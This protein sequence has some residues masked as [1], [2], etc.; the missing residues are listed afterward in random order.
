[1]QKKQGGYL[2]THVHMLCS[3]CSF[4]PQPAECIGDIT[5]NELLLLVLSPAFFTCS[6]SY[7]I[8]L[9]GVAG[10][11]SEQLRQMVD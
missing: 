3:V 9:S 10:L 7:P 2:A 4:T 5:S 1:M 8:L 11:A 6:S